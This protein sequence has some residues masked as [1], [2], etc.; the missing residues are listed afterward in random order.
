MLAIWSA[1][2]ANPKWKDALI[3]VVYNEQKFL[4]EHMFLKVQTGS[5]MQP[6]HKSVAVG[7]ALLNGNF[8]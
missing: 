3:W 1:H 6:K 7:R 8:S 4:L 5:K 2:T